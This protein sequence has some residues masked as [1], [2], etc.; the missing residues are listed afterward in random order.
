MM[1]IHHAPLDVLTHT[2]KGLSF[3][4]QL[5]SNK[6]GT[7]YVDKYTYSV[8]YLLYTY[9]LPSAPADCLAKAVNIH[10]LLPP[11]THTISRL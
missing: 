5:I 9:R 4:T 7:Y 8:T 10:Y 11:K 3:A 2:K 1:V 6:G